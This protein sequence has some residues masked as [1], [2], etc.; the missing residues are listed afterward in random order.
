MIIRTHSATLL[1][2]NAI[3]VEIECHEANAQQF[4]VGI[5]GLPDTAVKEARDRVMAAVRNSGFFAPFTGSITFNLAPADLKKEGP[6]FDLPLALAFLAGREGLSPER[7][8]ECCI[9]GELSLGG[10]IRPVRGILAIALEARNK[11]RRQLLVPRKVAAE[12]SV[13]Q[14][15][16]VI[17]LESLREAVQYLKGE[18]HLA[19]EPCRA[20]EFFD[21][22]AEY[23][24]DFAEVKGQ[25]DE[26]RAM[27]VAVAARHPLHWPPHPIAPAR[28][29]SPATDSTS[30][31]HNRSCAALA[32]ATP[33]A[34][35]GAHHQTWVQDQACL[36][37]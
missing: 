22:H 4:R 34:V 26:K 37:S 24:I 20:S 15:I 13:V 36:C 21:A 28:H 5:V 2:V 30:H 23:G 16:E 17:G 10:E 25:Q 12:A 11:G 7:L 27:E 3:E 9:V 32:A 35:A 31:C 14:G 19:P 33:P 8:A 6:A 1:G 18:K 29:A